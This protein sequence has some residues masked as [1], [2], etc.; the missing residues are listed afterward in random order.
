MTNNMF[1]PLIR[2]L[3]EH[4]APLLR[5][6]AR[7]HTGAGKRLLS[8]AETAAYLGRSPKAIHALVERGKIPVVR[9]DSRRFFDVADLDRWIE[10]HKRNA[11]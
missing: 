3:A 8:V 9:L 10:Q 7:G 1:D 5:P 4:L 2:A 11:R 6:A